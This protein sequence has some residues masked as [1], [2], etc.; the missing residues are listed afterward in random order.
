MKSVTKRTTK[1]IMHDI[2]SLS[3]IVG[4]DELLKTLAMFE[5]DREYYHIRDFYEGII[6][7]MNYKQNKRVQDYLNSLKL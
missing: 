7:Y 6:I 2:Q 4:K 3:D 5:Y 1:E